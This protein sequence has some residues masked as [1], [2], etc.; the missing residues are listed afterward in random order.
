MAYAATKRNMGYNGAAAYDLYGQQTA[1]RRQR[2]DR[3]PQDRPQAR[4]QTKARPQS[5]FLTA[6]ELAAAAVV[7][8]LVVF[9]QMKLYEVTSQVN[10]L[11]TELTALQEQQVLLRSEYD[12][13]VDLAAIEEIAV[14]QLGMSRPAGGQTVYVNLSGTDRAEVLTQGR[15]GLFSGVTRLVGEAFSNLGEYLS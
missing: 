5:A 9:S 7:L 10:A 1:V 13:S 11:Q 6:V 8:L 2:Q 4:P 14:S 12:S 15:S 3:L